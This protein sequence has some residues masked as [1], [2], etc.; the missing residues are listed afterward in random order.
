MAKPGV[1]VTPER[2]KELI[3]KHLKEEEQSISGLSRSLEK[4]G[5]KMHRLVLTGYLKALSDL[6]VLKE[7]EIPPSKV[8][9]TSALRE[10]NI[11]EKVGEKCM[12]LN[13]KDDEKPE[14]A[15][16]VLQKLFHR[17]IFLE[18]IKE[19]GFDRN[20]NEDLRVTGEER[21]EAKIS[22]TSAGY[23]LPNNDPAYYIEN[24]YNEYFNEILHDILI[25][26]FKVKRLV[27]STKQIK[28]EGM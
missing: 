18:E 26:T 5:Y 13:I 14:V 7:K 4:E 22:L 17:P 24:D 8:Y 1:F 19:C 9:T 23:K 21:R 16:F 20:P 3:I 27:H 6:G 25:E 28:L 2:L 11:Y 12:G 15:A 10:K